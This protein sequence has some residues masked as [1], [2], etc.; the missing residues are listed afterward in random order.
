MTNNIFRIFNP[1][2]PK[3]D[4]VQK[5]RAQVRQAQQTYRERKEAYTK[6]LER[7]VAKSKT[8]EAEL[9]RENERLQSTIQSLVGKLEQ[10]GVESP[11]E[12]AKPA[13]TELESPTKTNNMSGPAPP[14][15]RLGDVD[16]VA[17]GMD[18]V[19]TLE[20]P[21]LEHLH[22]DPDKPHDPSGHALTLSSQACAVTCPSNT[23]SPVSPESIEQHALP[24][25][26]LENLLALSTE[27]CNSDDQITPVQA[28]NLIRSQPHFG[29]FE[30]HGLRTLAESLM[31]TIK[32]HGFGAVIPQSVFRRL[33]FELLLQGKPF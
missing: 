15:A 2:A 4:R 10:H 13:L 3:E 19:L 16:P 7:E 1:Q 11:E 33:T 21:C 12:A 9:L 25:A 8:R 6:A 28:W 24:A 17:L 14:L 18:F 27:V 5:R 30:L 31:G 20:R 32:C 26:M 22:G 23:T 29:G